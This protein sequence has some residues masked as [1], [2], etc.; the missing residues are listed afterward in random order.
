MSTNEIWELIC[1]WSKNLGFQELGVS[2]IDLEEH[3]I[4][5]FNDWL[6]KSYH[7]E[8]EWMVRHANLRK[9]PQKLVPGAIRVISFRLNYLTEDAS[10]PVSLLKD[11]SKGYISRYSIGR[12]YHKVMRKKLKKISELI[13]EVVPHEYRVF[14]DSAPV[15]ETVFAE[16]AKLGW[17]GKNTLLLNRS[18]G[19]WFFLGEIFT[20]LPLPVTE[21]KVSAHCGRCTACIDVC[22]TKAIVEPYVV[23]ARR[24]ISYLTIELKGDIPEEF[25]EDM[26]NRIYGCDD[27]QLCCPWNRF[28]KLS[29]EKDFRE[30]HGLANQKLLSLF[31]WSEQDFLKKTEGSAIRRIGYER[32]RRNLS[33]ALGNA[34]FSWNIL[35]VLVTSLEDSSELVKRHVHWAINKH[36]GKL[37]SNELDRGVNRKIL[38]KSLDA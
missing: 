5:P 30:R 27:C 10:I 32:W 37:I 24:C 15:L 36:R 19:S 35:K 18:A 31:E 17:I 21:K 14:T 3:Q 34:P 6:A 38:S 22:P 20:T 2:N 7:G 12:D 29:G 23:D 4:E 1:N 13:N 9:N 8:M 33:V 25:R 16:K 28:A 26:G 11:K